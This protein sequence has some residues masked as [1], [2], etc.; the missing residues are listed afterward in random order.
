MRATHRI[1]L[2]SSATKIPRAAFDPP[3]SVRAISDNGCIAGSPSAGAE[4]CFAGLLM[5]ETPVAW[6]RGAG[7]R[8]RGAGWHC[9]HNRRAGRWHCGRTKAPLAIV[10][11]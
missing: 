9:A 6:T 4:G 8:L 1:V 5:Q 10:I 2:I 7:E 3:T 11:G